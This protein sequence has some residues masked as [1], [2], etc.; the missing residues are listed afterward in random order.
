L[1]EV[2]GRLE[3]VVAASGTTTTK[4][5]GVGPVVAAIT[6]G[7]TGDVGRSP[8]KGHFAAY[9]GSAPVEVL[10]GAEEDLPAL[11]E[12]RV[13]MFEPTSVLGILGHIASRDGR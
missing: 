8:N 6:L 12:G 11:H 5:F 2:K 7:M 10:L 3:A 1:A 13:R 4:I 9:N